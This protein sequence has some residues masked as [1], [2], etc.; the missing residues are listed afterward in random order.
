MSAIVIPFPGAY[1]PPVVTTVEEDLPW[2]IRRRP[3]AFLDVPEPLS[4]PECSCIVPH[5]T[6]L[7]YMEK[8]SSLGRQFTRFG[9]FWM[10]S[11]QGKLVV[12]TCRSKFQPGFLE[13]FP[14]QSDEIPSTS[15]VWLTGADS[16]RRIYISNL[17]D[18]YCN[19]RYLERISDRNFDALRKGKIAKQNLA[20]AVREIDLQLQMKDETGKGLPIQE[21][22]L[23]QYFNE[24]KKANGF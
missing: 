21:T 20:L 23:F 10:S 5:E 7:W 12:D 15:A 22:A 6:V 1:A 19:M 3:P 16:V 4:L 9:C 14:D 18:S 24:W 11:D 13:R 2:Q 8:V 17:E